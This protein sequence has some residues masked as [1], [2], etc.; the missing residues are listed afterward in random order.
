MKFFA[1]S[2]VVVFAAFVVA[3]PA[4]A[5]SQGESQVQKRQRWDFD[6]IKHLPVPYAW[7]RSIGKASVM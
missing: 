4:P 3:G 6:R 1:I 7:Y 2:S 5:N